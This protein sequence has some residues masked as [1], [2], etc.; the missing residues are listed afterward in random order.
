MAW[1]KSHEQYG[2]TYQ[3]SYDFGYTAVDECKGGG[4]KGIIGLVAAIAV[5]F[6]APA[7][8]SA[9]VSSGAIAAASATFASTAIGAGLGG[10]V[11]LAT[12][13]LQGGLL[14]AVGGGLGG[15]FNAGSAS[16]GVAGSADLSTPIGSS[17]LDAS[18]AA[19][20]GGIG[21]GASS[22]LAG[23]AGPIAGDFTGLPT[24]GLG[25]SS[26]GLTGTNTFGQ[27]PLLD[28][29]GTAGVNAVS[30]PLTDASLGLNGPAAAA[31]PSL[32]Q[33]AS[34]AFNNLSPNVQ[35]AGLKL[36]TQALGTLLTPAPQG[37]GVQAQAD[38]LNKIQGQNDQAFGINSAQLQAKNK[39]AGAVENIA[40]NYDPQYLGN[41]AATMAKNRD[42]A[43]WTDTEARL[44]TQG[45]SQQAIDAEHNRFNTASSQDVGTAYTGGVAQGTQQQAG[46]YAS[47]A[48]LRGDLQAPGAGLASDYNSLALQATNRRAAA[49]KSIQDAFGL[50]DPT[51]GAKKTVNSNVDPAT[52]PQ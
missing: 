13:G 14:G 16:A 20:D 29:G 50:G 47:G 36:G 1:D 48:S 28:T 6:A 11:G 22:A 18:G 45:Y 24:G 33:S 46:L 8:A 23:P 31:Q 3:T 40:A 26:A 42:A 2:T 19:V 32:L 7:I 35:Q 25:A 21:S 17:G 9:L 43:G 41:N 27:T 44:R 38:Y 5:P 30:S 37:A 12:G 52:A 15:Y 39:D 4:A 10:I 49:G 51:I 34:N